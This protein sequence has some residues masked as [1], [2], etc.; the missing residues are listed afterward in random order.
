MGP[1]ANRVGASSETAVV[2]RTL[3]AEYAWLLKHHPHA[4]VI[5]R[6]EVWEDEKLLDIL[7]ITSGEGETREVYFDVSACFPNR[8][9]TRPCPHCGEPLVS[10]KSMQC[11]HC[12]ADFHD[13]AHVIFRKGRDH[14][15]RVRERAVRRRE[16]EASSPGLADPRTAFD[17]QYRPAEVK[18]GVFV[19]RF[20]R[21][22]S[23]VDERVFR[24]GLECLMA[25]GCRG[26]VCHV[27][28][29]LG[30]IPRIESEQLGFLVGRITE[31][32]RF[33]M[34]ALLVGGGELPRLRLPILL[35]NYETEHEAVARLA[36]ELGSPDE[37]G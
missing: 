26:V 2:V 5:S 12:F 17:E 15:D 18:V 34:R 23:V 27:D 32:S 4:S 25:K 14:V 24:I 31:F 35:E 8:Q 16:L 20:P 7:T 13:P 3:W 33:G 22:Q 10:L 1:E 29:L 6:K 30:Q 36:S 19:L 11:R 9:P 28:Q 21:R 37:D